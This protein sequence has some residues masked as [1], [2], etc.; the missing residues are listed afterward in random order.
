M[1]PD[2][3]MDMSDGDLASDNPVE[4]VGAVLL[5]ALADLAEDVKGAR[6]EVIA[7][8][9]EVIALR[10]ELAEVRAEVTPV[11]EAVREMGPMAEKLAT[12]GLLGL[13]RQG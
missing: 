11:I 7:L 9:A 10:A 12:G 13:F 4:V 3:V 5:D 1:I 8:R 6:A 2:D